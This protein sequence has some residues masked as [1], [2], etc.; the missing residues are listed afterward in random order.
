MKDLTD[1]EKSIIQVR[2]EE[3]KETQKTTLV[4]WTK[5]FWFSVI[6]ALGI[7]GFIVGYLTKNE[8]SF[9]LFLSYTFGAIG[10]SM[11]VLGFIMYIFSKP[12]N[13]YVERSKKLRNDLIKD[14]KED[15]LLKK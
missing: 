9:I 6:F 8:L 12:T 11:G 10:V 15:N 7:L 5:I 3:I 14:I 2:L 1:K 4:V 13:E